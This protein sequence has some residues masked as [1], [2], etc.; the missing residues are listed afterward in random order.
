MAGMIGM[1][2][3]VGMMGMIV[4]VMIACNIDCR[5]RATAR[6]RRPLAHPGWSGRRPVAPL[7]LINS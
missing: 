7:A 4:V 5:A 6:E 3:M 2:R 1:G